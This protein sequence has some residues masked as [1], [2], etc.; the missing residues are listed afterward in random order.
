MFKPYKL[1]AISLFVMLASISAY[2][3]AQSE[4]ISGQYEREYVPQRLNVKSIHRTAA[5]P[6][7]VFSKPVKIKPGDV[8]SVARTTTY[9]QA[10]ASFVDVQSSGVSWPQWG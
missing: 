4:P 1:F 2:A 9:K 6:A 7:P 8:F 3:Q 5:L 10:P